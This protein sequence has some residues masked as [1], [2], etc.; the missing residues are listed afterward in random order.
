MDSIIDVSS[1]LPEPARSEM[2]RYTAIRAETLRRCYA[3]EGF[4][5]FPL[6]QKNR[7]YDEIRR[8]VEQ[9]TA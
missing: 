9:E 4:E 7:C 2:L 5:D 8:E 1:L 3:I 6:D